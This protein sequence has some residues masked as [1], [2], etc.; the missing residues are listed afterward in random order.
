[1]EP[2][3]YPLRINWPQTNVVWWGRAR[4]GHFLVQDI[5]DKGVSEREITAGVQPRLLPIP[6]AEI[7]RAGGQL[8]KGNQA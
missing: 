1:M 7:T 5:T 6:L 4:D 3:S 8:A 2:M